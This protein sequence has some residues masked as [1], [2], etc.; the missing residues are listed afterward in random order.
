MTKAIK[1]GYVCRTE[2][3]RLQIFGHQQ[4]RQIGQ[5]LRQ[6][7][8]KRLASISASSEMI[9]KVIRFYLGDW[10]TIQLD[11]DGSGGVYLKSIDRAI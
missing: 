8:K 6:G 7:G 9:K 1:S 3:F 4:Y 11:K 2:R 10:A 5:S